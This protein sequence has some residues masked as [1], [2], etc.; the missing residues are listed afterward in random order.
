MIFIIKNTYLS[1]LFL[2]SNGKAE[3]FQISLWYQKRKSSS[4]YYIKK[5]LRSF[6]IPT[7][8]KF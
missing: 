5:G 1:F 6:T 2:A 8:E 7:V 4:N 3:T